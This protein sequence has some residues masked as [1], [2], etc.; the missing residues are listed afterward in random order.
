M[1]RRRAREVAFKVLFQVDLVGSD[2]EDAL[3]H[4]EV[5]SQLTGKEMNFA[6][7]L[8]F[9][10]IDNMEAIDRQVAN[11][12][13][14]WPLDRMGTV[15]RTLLRM[16]AYEIIFGAEVH[17]VVAIDEAVELA[18]RFGDDNSK[19]FI[20]AILDHIREDRSEPLPGD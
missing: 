7:D 3:E 8:V 10:T 5:D 4:L 19:K 1:S 20:N 18:K 13:P 11:Y 14:D 6:R 9:G 2:I 16:A 15:D 17:P 12:S